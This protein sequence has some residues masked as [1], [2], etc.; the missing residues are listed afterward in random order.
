MFSEKLNFLSKN[1]HDDLDVMNNDGLIEVR[2]WAPGEGFFSVSS[3][4]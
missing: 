4:M 3:R 1:R 2:E